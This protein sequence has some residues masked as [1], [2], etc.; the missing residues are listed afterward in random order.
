MT[1]GGI[2]VACASAP[3]R[4]ARAIVRVSGDGCLDLLS[5]LIRPLP[6]G[7]SAARASFDLGGLG[8]P[9]GVLVFRA[10]A[11]YT[12]EDSVEILL[13]G[14]P[15]LVDRVVGALLTIDGVRQAEPGEFTARAFLNGKLSLDQAE[16]VGHLIAAERD[17]Q[18]RAG[19][20]LLS[21]AEGAACRAW[22]EEV[23]TL[24]ALVEA[25]IDF[26]DQE[27]VVPIAPA[28]LAR[29]VRTLADEIE[30]RVGGG[31]VREAG[32]ALPR[33]VLVGEPNAGKS[34]LFNALLG[35]VRVVVSETPGS[36]RDVIA[37]EL[38][39]SDVS[40]AP[41]RVEL[42]DLPGL[43]AGAGGEAGRAA[44]VAANEAIERGD[45]LI[46]CD[47][48]G[49]FAG[50]GRDD[51]VVIR[52][53]TKGDL[54]GEGGMAVCALDGWRLDVLKRAIGDA[55]GGGGS[56]LPARRAGVL[57]RTRDA[58]REALGHIDVGAHALD[59]PELVAGSL[60]AAL[61]ALGELTGAVHPDEVIGRLFSSFCVGK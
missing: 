53:R 41:V 12:G 36:T 17:D 18:L 57:V 60:R 43:D 9:V 2:I 33:V 32:S 19:K 61:D 35:R 56:G 45:V 55:V 16:G 13:P 54:P 58:L 48:S 25:G 40:A 42:C 59:G 26:T 31:V 24:L 27:D 47:P 1:T 11:S 10:P 6:R 50:L 23:T 15:A 52:V 51:V 22:A 7:R 3:G 46:H 21:G 49:R 5:E 28:E 37:E 8:L 4:S 38:D 44:Q 14:N 29:R 34:T 39:L 20:E 30:G